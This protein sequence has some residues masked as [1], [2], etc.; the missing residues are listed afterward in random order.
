MQVNL[1][2]LRYFPYDFSDPAI[3]F[4]HP[5]SGKHVLKFAFKSLL[6]T[7]DLADPLSGTLSRPSRHLRCDAKQEIED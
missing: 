5:R 3:Q 2:N 4:D 1:T 7:Q 6:G